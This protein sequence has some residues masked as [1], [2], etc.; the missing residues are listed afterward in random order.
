MLTCVSSPGS[1]PGQEPQVENPACCLLFFSVALLTSHRGLFKA[2]SEPSAQTGS[3][4]KEEE[5]F[6]WFTLQAH[7]LTSSATHTSSS[8]RDVSTTSSLTE[9]ASSVAAGIIRPCGRLH[10]EGF[11]PDGNC[12][13]FEGKLLC[14][15]WTDL[16]NKHVFSIWG[17]KPT[18]A[19]TSDLSLF[20]NLV[21]HF[22]LS[23]LYLICFSFY[24]FLLIFPQLS[25]LVSVCLSLCFWGFCPLPC[26]QTGFPADEASEEEEEEQLQRERNTDSHQGDPQ[27][28]GRVVLQTAGVDLFLFFF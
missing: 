19:L 21:S 5:G 17:L 23:S 27:E 9:P 26:C 13:A 4:K 7:Q 14:W 18:F 12:C 10:S 2:K 16:Y 15:T 20:E 25:L 22:P 28:E 24:T 11:L 8:S 6:W 1:S 3:K